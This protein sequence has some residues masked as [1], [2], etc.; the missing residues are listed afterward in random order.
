[1]TTL[2]QSVADADTNSNSN[3]T[4]RTVCSCQSVHQWHFRKKQPSRIEVAGG[5]EW[6]ERPFTCRRIPPARH[7]LRSILQEKFS[8]CF[9]RFV[10]EKRRRNSCVTLADQTGSRSYISGAMA[11]NVRHLAGNTRKTAAPRKHWDYMIKNKHI[12]RKQN[13][14]LSLKFTQNKRNKNNVKS[15]IKILFEYFWFSNKKNKTTTTNVFANKQ[16]IFVHF[17]WYE[18]TSLRF[19]F[20]RPYFK[21]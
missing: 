13:C 7:R 9:E 15:N 18:N 1:M 8:D 5:P 17:M 14:I 3:V 12:T 21:Y 19:F 6:T 20:C 10:S 11:K 2:N 16:C 4:R